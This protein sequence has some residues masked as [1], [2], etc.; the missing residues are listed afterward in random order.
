MDDDITDQEF[1]DTL[2]EMLVTDP[3][4]FDKYYEDLTPG[5]KIAFNRMVDRALTERHGPMLL[6]II[7]RIN[8]K[9]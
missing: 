8:D 9:N 5:E 6:Q 2:G 4:K 3:D 7:D 1:L